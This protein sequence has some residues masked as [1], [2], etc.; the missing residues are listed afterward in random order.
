VLGVCVYAP[1]A[2]ADCTGLTCTSVYIETLNAEA[3]EMA[4]V[5]D[6]WVKTTGTE[7]VLT[8]TADS[9]V[10]LKLRKEA[11]EINRVYAM[12]LTAFTTDPRITIRLVGEPGQ[13]CL[14]A[15]A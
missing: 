4:D 15:Y 3:G 13:P 8:C 10:W 11:P 14:I 5:D 1:G 2:L 6:V 9:G 7:S 12:L